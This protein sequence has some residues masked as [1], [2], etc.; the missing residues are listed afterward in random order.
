MSQGMCKHTL[1][2]NALLMSVRKLQEKTPPCFKKTWRDSEKQGDNLKTKTMNHQYLFWHP[3]LWVPRIYISLYLSSV[4]SVFAPTH[5][6]THPQNRKCKQLNLLVLFC[7]PSPP[8]KKKHT[9]HPKRQPTTTND[10]LVTRTTRDS[11]N[12]ISTPDTPPGSHSTNRPR[13]RY[14]R[15]LHE[16][17]RI[18]TCSWCAN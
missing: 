1:L 6:P 5:P 11:H 4:W 8:Q 13:M 16:E 10:T 3:D 9:S 14:D 2:Q 18:R 7:G 12:K 15:V 17:L